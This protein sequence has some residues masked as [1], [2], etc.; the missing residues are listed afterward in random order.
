MVSQAAAIFPDWLV[1]LLNPGMKPVFSLQ[2]VSIPC[3]TIGNM[4]LKYRAGD[5]EA[6]R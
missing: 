2:N 6:D 4:I 5:Q 1:A 3:Y